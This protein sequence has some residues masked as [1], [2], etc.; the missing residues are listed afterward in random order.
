LGG[1]EK[2]GYYRDKDLFGKEMSVEMRI[3]FRP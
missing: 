2:M 1:V 3:I